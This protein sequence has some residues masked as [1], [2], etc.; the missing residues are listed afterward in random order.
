MVSSRLSDRMAHGPLRARLL[1]L[2][3]IT[4]AA[5]ALLRCSNADLHTT[6]DPRLLVLS[7]SSVRGPQKPLVSPVLSGS[8]TPPL[9]GLFSRGII[10]R[11]KIFFLFSSW[12]YPGENSQRALFHVKAARGKRRGAH[13][14][15]GQHLALGKQFPRLFVLICAYFVLIFVFFT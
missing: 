10:F 1:E 13:L 9:Q 7:I 6:V 5:P 3:N 14:Q 2:Y 8:P 12:F 15:V 4:M 11:R